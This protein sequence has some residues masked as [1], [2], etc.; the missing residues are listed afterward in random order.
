MARPISSANYEGLINCWRERLSGHAWIGGGTSKDVQKLL[1][2][3]EIR[4]R[5]NDSALMKRARTAA[6]ELAQ[7]V[8]AFVPT[9]SRREQVGPL[10]RWIDRHIIRKGSA[11]LVS[12]DQRRSMLS[13]QRDSVRRS[14]HADRAMQ[15]VTVRMSVEAWGRLNALRPQLQRA[16]SEQVTLGKAIERLIAAYED[17]RP[18]KFR[19][20]NSEKSLLQT[21][22]LFPLLSRRRDR[23]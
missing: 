7:A 6:A 9:D 16:T 19:K 13:R 5:A 20:T 8:A 15:A 11:L 1:A 23:P 14:R 17:G 10:D 22:S 12:E 3:L 21:E 4:D 18:A 2:M